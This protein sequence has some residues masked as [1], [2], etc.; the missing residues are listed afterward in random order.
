LGRNADEIEQSGRNIVKYYAGSPKFI[1]RWPLHFN[2]QMNERMMSDFFTPW[3]QRRAALTSPA[4]LSPQPTTE[5][6]GNSRVQTTDSGI[7][8]G[9]WPGKPGRPAPTLIFF[10]GAIEEMLNDDYQRQC[11]NILADKGYITVLI[12]G[13]CEGREIRP[14]EPGGLEGWRYRLEHGDDFVP[15]VNARASELLDYLIARG[16]TDPDRIAACGIS[17]GGFLAMHF[18]ASEPRVRCAAVYCPVINLGTLQLW[19]KGAEQDPLV[20]SLDLM[21]SADKLVGKPLWIVVGDQDRPVDTDYVIA[22]ARKISRL[23]GQNARVELH[24][25]AEPGGHTTPAGSDEKSAAWIS[26]QFEKDSS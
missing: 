6:D 25:I 22:F 21:E 8:F 10:G 18:A 20:R 1:V 16:Y 2:D 23:S 26:Q 14:G 12:D 9:I 3:V 4:G 11:G 13:P 17:R 24:V 15:E 19:F 7:R 5:G